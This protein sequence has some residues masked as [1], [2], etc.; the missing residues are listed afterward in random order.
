MSTGRR[1]ELSRPGLI[2]TFDDGSV[3]RATTSD[4][5]VKMNLSECSSPAVIGEILKVWPNIAKTAALTMIQKYGP[6]DEACSGPLV[7]HN[8]GPWRRTVVYAEEVKHNFPTPHH[9]RR[10][11]CTWPESPGRWKKLDCSIRKPCRF[12]NFSLAHLVSDA[13]DPCRFAGL[14]I[15]EQPSNTAVPLLQPGNVR[16]P[17]F[18]WSKRRWRCVRILRPER[19]SESQCTSGVTSAATRL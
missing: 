15:A 8:N 1:A 13:F 11:M 10:R 16:P 14:V 3:W 6:P 18:L 17:I 2:R 7:W 12:L 5:K 4:P 19:A 9:S